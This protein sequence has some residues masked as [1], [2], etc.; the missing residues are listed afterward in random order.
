ME[1]KMNEISTEAYMKSIIDAV[2]EK[3]KMRRQFNNRM[4]RLRGIEE[5]NEI[6]EDN[7]EFS[8]DDFLLENKTKKDHKV[9]LLLSCFLIIKIKVIKQIH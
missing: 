7:K 5:S 4:K 9:V 8:N 2:K 6:K 3:E 1:T